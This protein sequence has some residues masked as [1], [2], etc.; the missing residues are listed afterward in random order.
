MIDIHS[1]PPPFDFDYL[2]PKLDEIEMSHHQNQNQ[3]QLQHLD[4]GHQGQLDDQD[5]GSIKVETTAERIVEVHGDGE[6][7]EGQEDVSMN[8]TSLGTSYQGVLIKGW[9]EKVT[10]TT[11]PIRMQHLHINEHSIQGHGLGQDQNQNQMHTQAMSHSVDLLGQ[12]LYQPYAI[13]GSGSYPQGQT[14]P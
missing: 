5:Q 4:N 11:S 7:D 6:G 2:S 14:T 1:S 9:R 3:T 12:N 8:N 10:N 13:P